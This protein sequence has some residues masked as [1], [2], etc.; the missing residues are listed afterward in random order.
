MTTAEL[1]NS[2][3]VIQRT[4][5]EK[6]AIWFHQNRFWVL[7]LLSGSIQFLFL[8][9]MYFPPQT[10]ETDDDIY[11]EIQFVDNVKVKQPD[12]EVPPAEGEIRKTDELKKEKVED[13]RIVGAQNPFAIGATPPVDLSPGVKPPYTPEARSAGIE[14]M[15]VLELVVGEDGRVLRV[16]VLKGL[17]HG[18]DQSA[19]QTYYS[20]RFTP[21]Y[22]EGK[23][24]T[25]KINV[26]IRFQLI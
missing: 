24:I 12:V 26:P 20:K 25:V 10:F 3:P 14:G 9:L 11:E 22:K 7:A 8:Y 2:S 15:L 19:V 23:P 16:R 1:T 21:A 5:K 6:F 4:G 13:Q 18:L 17:G